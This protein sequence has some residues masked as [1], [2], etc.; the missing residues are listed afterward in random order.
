[1]PCPFGQGIFKEQSMINKNKTAARLLALL[2]ALA[3]PLGCAG[4][5][6]DDAAEPTPAVTAAPELA[7]VDLGSGL[8]LVSVGR[9]AGLFVED[10]SDDVVS[11][12]FCI[13]VKNNGGSDVQYAHITL[14]RGSESYNFD[15]GTLPVGETVQALELE[16]QKLPENTAELSAAL[17]LFAAFDEPL[18]MH[19]DLFEVTASDSTVT[20]KNLSD[21]DYSQVYVYYKNAG[22]DMLIGGI[23]Y[24]VG[25]PLAAGESVNCYTSHY[26]EGGSRLL[27]VSY[28]Q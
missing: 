3:L 28:V 5:S 27:F 20:V 19:S 18:S 22:S 23:T 17:T 26:S 25:T 1:M 7:G 14:T 21:E 8:E 4:C 2:L 16:R 9:Y 24:R 15:L 11:D 10:G 6:R 12:V 13:C